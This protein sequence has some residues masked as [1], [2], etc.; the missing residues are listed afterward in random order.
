MTEWDPDWDEDDTQAAL[1]W[2]Q[3]DRLR[4][5]CGQPIDETTTPEAEELYA[6]ELWKCH[7]CATVDGALEQFRKEG[8]NVAGLQARAVRR[9]LDPLM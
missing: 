3:E 8:G 4:C 6:A 5:R 2:Q 1:E 9:Q 7:A